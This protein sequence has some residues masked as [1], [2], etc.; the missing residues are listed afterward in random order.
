MAFVVSPNDPY[1]TL[2]PDPVLVPSK[3]KASGN[4]IIQVRT[5]R[6]THDTRDTHVQHTEQT[7][8]S[9]LLD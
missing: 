9:S 5:T 8:S 7:S 4:K 2:G 6:T 1:S 3:T